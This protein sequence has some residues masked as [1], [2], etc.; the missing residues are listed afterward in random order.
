[1]RIAENPTERHQSVL[2]KAE[3]KT[4]IVEGTGSMEEIRSASESQVLQSWQSMP[5]Y[6]GKFTY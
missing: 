3:N 5:E 6:E 1:M 2:S 4:A